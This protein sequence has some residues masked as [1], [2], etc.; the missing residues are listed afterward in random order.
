MSS[1]Y[2]LSFLGPIFAKSKDTVIMVYVFHAKFCY[3]W[4]YYTSISVCDMNLNRWDCAMYV[5]F[6]WIA[7]LFLFFMSVKNQ[8][9]YF[10]SFYVDCDKRS[11]FMNL[12][13]LMLF[14]GVLQ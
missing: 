5:F 14:P 13:P 8:Y 10:N 6:Y 9:K 1:I 7:L 11:Y 4:N 2:K 12:L 3:V